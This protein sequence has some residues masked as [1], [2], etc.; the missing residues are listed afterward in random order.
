MKQAIVVGTRPDRKDQLK[1]CLNSLNTSYDVLTVDCDGYEVGKIKWV[2]NNTDLD[3]FIFLQDTIEVKN[4]RFIDICF[5]LPQSVSICNYPFLFGCYLGK[6]KRS[7]LEKMS[8]PE[9]KDKLGS[10]EYEMQIGLDYCR[11]EKPFELFDDLEDVDNFVEKW[12]HKVMKIENDYL[13]KYK[14]CYNRDQI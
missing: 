4:P 7:V 1:N 2:L 14:T 12:G 10:V 13:I 6:Y 3:E 9:I 11:F 8:L 5:A